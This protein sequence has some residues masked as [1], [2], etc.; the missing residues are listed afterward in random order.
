[1]FPASQQ[2]WSKLRFTAFFRTLMHLL[3]LI[4]SSAH[5]EHY[6]T[7]HKER[8]L[9]VQKGNNLLCVPQRSPVTHCCVCLETN[10]VI[11]SLNTH[12]GPKYALGIYVHIHV[13]CGTVPVQ[14]NS[15]HVL[16]VVSGS[17]PQSASWPTFHI[18]IV[19]AHQ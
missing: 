14:L 9:C 17:V 4:L 12:T 2:L 19:P 5:D 18:A 11:I 7:R 10:D 3:L 6:M 16:H 1:M 13:N 15:H 8:C